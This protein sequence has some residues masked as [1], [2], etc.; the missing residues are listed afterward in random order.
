MQAVVG[1]GDFLLGIFKAFVFGILV[2]TAGCLRGLQCGSGAGAVGL[3][4]TRAVVAGI[5]LIVFSNAIMIAD[6]FT[7]G[8]GQGEQLLDNFRM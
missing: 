1:M 6:I 4:T 7:G 5:T 8:L 2:A 3:A